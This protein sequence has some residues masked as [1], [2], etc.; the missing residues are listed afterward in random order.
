MLVALLASPNLCSRRPLFEQYDAIVQARTVRRPEQADAAVLALPDGGALAVSIDG[1]GRRVAA[2]P[3]RGTL[4]AALECA[5]NLA[6]VGARPLGATNNLNFGNPE[7]PHIAWQ[8]SES[9]RGLGDACRALDVPIVG[10]NVSLYNEGLEGPVYPTPVIGVVGRLPDARRAGRSGFQAQGDEIA[11]AGPFDPS[12]AASELAKLR[13][14][15]LPDGLPAFELEQVIAAQAAVR[16]AVAAG[17]LHSAH[18]VAEG[19]LAV[20]LAEC[21]LAGGVGAAIQLREHEWGSHPPASERREQPAWPLAALFGEGPG[22][23]LVSGPEDALAVLEGRTHLLRL[24]VV[25]GEE[26][27]IATAA[28]ELRARLSELRAAHGSMAEL[29][30]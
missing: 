24:G 3:Y 14:Q 22:G 7:K 12:L 13:G 26:L 18:D 1:N 29:F 19:G 20:A 25:G 4:E 30:A 9:V 5:A 10:G 28:G 6:C 23:F 11:L 21:C 16:D 2:D 8:L 27:R 15:V 17:A